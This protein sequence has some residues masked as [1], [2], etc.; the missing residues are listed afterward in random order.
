MTLNPKDLLDLAK[1]GF[2]PKSPVSFDTETSGLFVDDGARVATV[3]VAWVDFDGEWADIAKA[4]DNVTYRREAV[5]PDHEYNII[6]MAWPFDQ[7]VAGTG[8]PEDHGQGTLFADA[9]NLDKREW[10]ALLD[11]LV[12]VGILDDGTPN[13]VPHNAK[14]DVTLMN[15]GCRRWPGVGRNLLPA[16]L[17]DTQVVNDLLWP[18]ERTSLK[19][20][21]TRLFG[22]EYADESKKVQA[23]LKKAKLPAGRW[24]LMPWDIIGDYADMDPRLTIMLYLR[25][26]WEIDHNEGGS[27]LWGKKPY[28]GLQPQD[29]PDAV[30]Q[31]IKRRHAVMRLLTNME[32]RGLPYAEIESREAAIEARKR[33]Q[34]VAEKLPFKPTIDS[35]KNYYFGD[36]VT[37]KGV[38]CLSLVP[39]AT[40]DKGAPQMTEEIV[41]RMLNDEMPF[42]KEWAEYKKATTAASMWYE[43]YADKMGPDGRLRTSF[44]QN[45]TISHR[46]SVERV[47]LQAI[48][49]DYRLS[50]HTIL[51]GLPTPRQLIAHAVKHGIPGWKLWE[52]DLAQAELRVAAWFAKCK[53]MLEMIES[54]EDLHTFTTKE[55]FHIDPT[56]AQFGAFRQVG[57]RGNFSLIFGSGAPTFRGMVR[58]E[59]GIELGEGQAFQIV[60]AWNALY[61]E[62]GV[63][64]ETHMNRVMRRQQRHGH[65]WI[66]LLNGE[67]RWFGKYEDAHKAFN[68]R[69]QPNLAQFGLDWMLRTE[70]IMRSAE[71]Q[72]MADQDGI[73]GAGLLLTIH[74]S[75]VVLLPD[76]KTGDQLASAVQNAGRE[77]WRN[78]F[79]VP[80]DVDA[81]V[82]SK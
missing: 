7:G 74:D 2:M 30:Y 46:F 70:Q 47:N 32:W 72:R 49:Q 45:G 62:F 4:H 5:A 17:W 25:Q 81:K 57:K 37:E 69:V 11:W 39:Y 50:S 29:G 16:I 35:A 82:W 3:S 24:D 26:R 6:S 80:G 67:R 27:W 78:T 71:V 76:N 22:E 14:F 19:P 38:K 13:L 43:G 73:G 9:D 21:A 65:G 60:R 51:E 63:A 48:P 54:G 68:Q 8:K 53:K 79:D 23:Y 59:T 12:M 31:Y 20:T 10:E 55:L 34:Q 36:G 33:A 61:P 1:A 44:K 40:T 56:H 15:K 41:G 66:D 58:K 18:L 77:I 52:F 28:G 42:I 75:Q 64:I